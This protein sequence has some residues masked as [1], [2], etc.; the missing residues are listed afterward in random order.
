MAALAQ[1]NIWFNKA[2]CDD[3]ERMYFEKLSGAKAG[4]G[5][6]SLSAQIQRARQHIKN[7]LDCVDNLVDQSGDIDMALAS[8][9]SALELENKALRKV[10]DD[11][12]GLIL[13]LENRVATL[14]GGK[15]AA[16]A[17]APPP[18]KAEPEEEEDDDDVDLFGSDDEEEDAEKARVT[19]ER[20]KAYAEKK[21]KKPQV[22]AKTSVLL[23]VK[24]WDDETDMDEMARLVK[25]IEMDGLNWGATKLV[26]IGYGIKKLQVMCTVE[27]AKV[28][29]DELSEKIEEFEDYVQ[30][31]DIAAMNKI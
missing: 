19:A 13:K 28:S 25:E 26:P 1:E 7:S 30:S 12:K 10:T 4:G 8:K 9:L 6:E 2:Q 3:A 17:A 16:P 22:I 27:D 18:K 15:S 21:A 11:L 24:P 23:D 5:P 29:V 31:V 14:E 20:L